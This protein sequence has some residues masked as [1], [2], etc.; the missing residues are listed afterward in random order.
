KNPPLYSV[1]FTYIGCTTIFDIVSN[2]TPQNIIQDPDNPNRI[3]AVCMYAP[4]GD[5]Y[6]FPNRKTKYY[7]STNKGTTWTFVADVPSTRSGFPVICLA[8][9]GNELISNHNTNISWVQMTHF[10]YD[11]SPG[12]GSFTQLYPSA[13][14][15]YI[16]PRTVTTNSVTLSNKFVNISAASGRDSCFWITG[17]SLGPSP[18]GFS[19]WHSFNTEPAEDYSIAK[20]SDGRIGILYHNGDAIFY[21]NYGDIYFME[22]TDN[23]TTFGTPTKIYD[24][25]ISPTGDS[26]GHLNGIQLIYRDNIPKAVFDICKRNPEANRTF[27]PNDG[28]NHIRFWSTS[29]PGSDP[30][31]SI[32]IA[33]TGSVGYHPLINTGGNS[34]VLTCICRPTI[35]VS[36]NGSVLFVAFMVPSNHVGG[37]V[38]TVSFNDVWF[39]YSTNS[40]SNWVAPVKINPVTPIRDWSYPSLSLVNDY[41]GGNYYANLLM[42]ADSIPG[43][44]VNFSS[45]GQS[46]AK[47][48]FARI[49]LSP[50]SVNNISSEIPKEYQLYQNYPNPFNPSTII[51]FQ[52]PKLSS[53]NANNLSSPH[54][55]GGDLVTLKIYD[56]LGKEIA[57]LVNEKL[58]P[59]TYEIPFSISQFSDNQLSSGIYFYKLETENFTDVKRMV[60]I[61]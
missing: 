41:T 21:A 8:S 45:N 17:T 35:G 18:G 23:G 4:P 38:D 59:G 14:M 2:G 1:S 12:Q 15:D 61:K 48:M 6:Q 52:I 58:S 16:W 31:R 53:P 27:S 11:A 57:T 10:Y 40:G 51:K 32:K 36:S 39:M 28:R 9:N 55:L 20:G 29:L 3:H 25:N 56:I 44:Y 19:P 50:I 47:F 42:L 5:G 26:L 22:S 43:S 49:N 60:L 30:N 13:Y 37:S 7:Y 46:F 34:D 54:A 33:D 24:A